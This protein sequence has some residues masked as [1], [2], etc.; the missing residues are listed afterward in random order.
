VLTLAV[1]ALSPRAA[2]DESPGALGIPY[3]GRS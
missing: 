3:E 2:R 1:L